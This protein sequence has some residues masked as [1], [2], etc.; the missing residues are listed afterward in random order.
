MSEEV[1]DHD[2]LS[3][4]EVE[5]RSNNMTMYPTDKIDWEAFFTYTQSKA[6]SKSQVKPVDEKPKNIDEDEE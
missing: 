6:A 1:S 3:S 4:D 2:D 5:H